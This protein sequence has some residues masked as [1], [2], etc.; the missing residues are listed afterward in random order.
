MCCHQAT[1]MTTMARIANMPIV[2]LDIENLENG[3]WILNIEI[4]AHRRDVWLKP[5]A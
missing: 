4:A 2:M 5:H 1:T 3:D